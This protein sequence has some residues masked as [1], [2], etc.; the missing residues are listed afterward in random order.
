[1]EPDPVPAALDRAL[2]A[3]L[4]PAGSSVLLAV[5]G[6]ADSMALLLGAAEKAPKAGWRLTVG[7]VHHGWRGRSADRDLLFVA[8]YARRLGLP[9]HSRRRDARGEA[10]ELKISPEAGARHA[11]YEALA[12]MAREAGHCLVATA[13]QLDDR[14]ESYWMAR[15]R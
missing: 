2:A 14:L 3:G 7:H 11:R 4:M 15:E 10:R 13:H 6:G 9:F 5:S 12:E 8:G 1:M